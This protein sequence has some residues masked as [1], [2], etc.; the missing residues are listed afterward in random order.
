MRQ[1][2]SAFVEKIEI[3]K[4]KE[5]PE[6]GYNAEDKKSFSPRTDGSLDR[7]AG[8]VIDQDEKN[9]YKNIP[10]NERHIEISACTKENK[11]LIP[12]RQQKESK[13]NR[14]EKESE[15]ERVEKHRGRRVDQ[16]MITSF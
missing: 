6:I 7:P 2:C 10:R 1:V 3:F 11:P 15:R 12:C 13:E 16:D 14:G 9:E 5:R 8:D 4:Q